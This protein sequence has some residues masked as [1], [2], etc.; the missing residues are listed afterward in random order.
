MFLRSGLQ[1]LAVVNLRPGGHGTELRITLRSEY[2]G[3]AFLTLWLG[4]AILFNIGILAA[5]LSG[6][7]HVQDLGF[8]IGFPI[9]GVGI[10]A[11][12]RLIAN[13]DRARLLDFIRQTTGAQDH[14]VSW[15]G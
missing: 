4:L 1:M 5:A 8:T 14:L 2:F 10:V 13:P 11:L 7:A 15:P 6:A 12:N 9:F 3:A